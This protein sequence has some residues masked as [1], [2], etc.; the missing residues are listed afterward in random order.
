MASTLTSIKSF[1]RG[2]TSCALSKG[3]VL[4]HAP[5]RS[6]SPARWW[7]SADVPLVPWRKSAI[8]TV[9]SG[10]FHALDRVGIVRV[11]LFSLVIIST[12]DSNSALNKDSSSLFFNP[13][14]CISSSIGKICSN[15]ITSTLAGPEQCSV[16]C[17]VSWTMEEI[18]KIAHPGD[19]AVAPSSSSTLGTISVRSSYPGTTTVF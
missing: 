13:G 11:H 8:C 2:K 5:R 14:F 15:V 17:S 4:V 16:H 7:R 12:L 19:L 6:N 18:E 9:A 1:D 3:R 10:Y